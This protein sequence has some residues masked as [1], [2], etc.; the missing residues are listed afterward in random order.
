MSDKEDSKKQEVTKPVLKGL[1]LKTTKI[2]R[3][4]EDPLP[5]ALA[6]V[7]ESAVSQP[8]SG[9]P[10]PPP[11]APTMFGQTRKQ[12]SIQPSSKQPVIRP[13]TTVRSN[14]PKPVSV[15]FQPPPL[16]VEPTVEPTV[17]PMIQQPVPTAPDEPIIQQQPW[18]TDERLATLL[19]PVVLPSSEELTTFETMIDLDEST[20]PY[21]LD[22]SSTYYP[23]DRKGFTRYMATYYSSNFALPQ[24][25]D[26]KI[27]PNACN[28]MELQTYKYQAFV[29]EFIRQGSP[30]RGILVYHGLGSGKTCTSIAAAEALYGQADKKIIVMTPISLKENFLNEMMFCGFRHYRLKNTWVSI[31]LKDESTKLF[32]KQVLNLSDSLIA[33]ISKRSSE[34]QVIWLPDLSKPE[35]ESTFEDLQDW[36]RSAIREQLYSILESKYKFIGYTG[37]TVKEMYRIATTEPDYFDNSVIIIDEVHNI[38]RLI[39]GK[40][41]PSLRVP[42]E[43]KS[44]KY[45]EPVTVDT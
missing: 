1:K 43:G 28:E 19:P 2:K 17:E 16:R 39:T 36:E 35:A 41:E 30:Y 15:L 7:T 37:Y 5:E 12:S 44:L 9:T 23:Q 8:Y 26:K 34:K 45:Y 3:G 20:N 38:T 18:K 32:A 40:L 4:P 6:I 14:K 21:K 22:E 33:S 11:R 29:R 31:P 10:A 25:I 24:V 13:N 42:K 27:N